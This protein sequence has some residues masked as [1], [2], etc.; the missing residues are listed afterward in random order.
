[1]SARPGSLNAFAGGFCFHCRLLLSLADFENNKKKFSKEREAT[2]VCSTATSLMG[3]L[4][5]GQAEKLHGKFCKR[6][7]KGPSQH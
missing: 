5:A 4:S 2:A 7:D 3:L 1:M 6:D